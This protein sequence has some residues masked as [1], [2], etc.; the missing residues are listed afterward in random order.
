M[1]DVQLNHSQVPGCYRIFLERGLKG[2]KPQ[3]HHLRDSPKSFQNPFI[4]LIPTLF[5]HSARDSQRT[6]LA[7]SHEGRRRA[8]PDIGARNF[9]APACSTLA[10]LWS[11]SNTTGCRINKLVLLELSGITYQVI[12]LPFMKNQVK[13]NYQTKTK[14]P[15]WNVN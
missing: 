15:I 8:R 11:I 14:S 13:Y 3:I 9:Q 10:S 1:C 2:F 12:P 4:L 5:Q 7:A 6:M